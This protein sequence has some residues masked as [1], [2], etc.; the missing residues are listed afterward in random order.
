MQ[1]TSAPP[2]AGAPRPTMPGSR[3]FMLAL[4]AL[5]GV[6][7]RTAHADPLEPVPPA[8][9]AAPAPSPAPSSPPAAPSS[10]PGATPDTTTEEPADPDLR[11]VFADPHPTVD[12]AAGEPRTGTVRVGAYGDNDRTTVLRTL[13]VLS[14]SWGRWTLSGT[15]GVDAVTSASVDVRSSPAL[16]KVDVVTSASGRSS[17]SGGEMTDTRYQVTGAAGWKD[18]AGHAASVSS[19]VAKETDYASVS[20]GLNSS[21][22][23]R[24]RLTTVLGGVTVTDNWI[25]SVL[26][27]TLHRKMIQVGWSAGFARV[28]TRDDA[29]RIRYDGKVAEG[30]QGSPYRN[31]RFGDW[32]AHL[33]SQQIT[34]TNTLGSAQGLLELL[35]G[36]RVSHA[37][38]IEWVHSLVPNV[39]LHPELRL[40]HDSWGVNSLS[41]AVDLRIAR[42]G[43]RAEAGYRYYR[44]TGASFFEDKYTQAPEMY[45][46]YTSDKEL[47]PQQG[48][49]LR[50]DLSL[51][52]V[53]ADGPSDTRMRLDF[54]IDAVRYRYPG[55]TLL[56]ARDGAFASIGLTWER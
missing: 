33:G 22:D 19:A 37:A 1:L 15:V 7:S 25:S 10:A 8:T 17:S 3:V 4:L 46:N 34:F 32:M 11:D 41:A 16:S 42:P 50:L 45:A 20:A 38:V 53:E 43:W 30:Y 9:E 36:S 27:D 28:L 44:Q 40:G 13:G 54:Q 39:G 12:P 35:P 29:I 21:Y 48:H 47:G 51:V 52:L 5:C 55:F 56:P 31:V 24:D 18:S 23:L 14:Q 6:V 2:T 26:D 49:L